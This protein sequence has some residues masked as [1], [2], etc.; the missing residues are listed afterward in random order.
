MRFGLLFLT[1]V[2]IIGC[3]GKDPNEPVMVPVSGTVSLDGKPLSGA[4]VSFVPTGQTLGQGAVGRTDKD[5]SFTLH[6]RRGGEGAATGSYKVVISK[7]VMPDGSDVHAD[8]KTPPMES[9]AKEKLLPR[10][11]DAERTTLSAIVSAG[12]T[13]LEFPLTSSKT[14]K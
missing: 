10:Y 1:A 12:G 13:R 5:G 14:G 11:S 7:R 6:G 2:V 9:P 3:T 8:D 4:D